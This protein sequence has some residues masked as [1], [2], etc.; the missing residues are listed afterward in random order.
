MPSYTRTDS[1][2]P[3]GFL[4]TVTGA[5]LW[6]ATYSRYA[7]NT[8]VHHNLQTFPTRRSSDLPAINTVAGG[9]VV[10]GSG[11]KLGDTAVL[12][13]AFNPTGSITFTLF[14]IGR[15]QV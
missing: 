4:P 7:H 3:G 15:A 5:Y 9:T 12:S 8:T 14:K 1:T 10:I 2:N 11:A 6:T 13:G